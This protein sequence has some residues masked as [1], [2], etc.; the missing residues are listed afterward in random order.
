MCWICHLTDEDEPRI[1]WVSP[2]RSVETSSLPNPLNETPCVCVCG[3]LSTSTPLFH[4]GALEVHGGYISGVYCGG[5]T[6]VMA[7]VVVTER[8]ARMAAEPDT[9]L[10]KAARL[11]LWRSF[12]FPPTSTS[13]SL[14]FGPSLV[15]SAC[16]RRRLHS[17]SSVPIATLFF[18][19]SSEVS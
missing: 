12:T 11:S 8:S 1:K 18:G 2:C 4:A 5:S 13:T 15:C 6:T 10:L 16:L 14:R 9:H 19:H 7:R 3:C 17:G